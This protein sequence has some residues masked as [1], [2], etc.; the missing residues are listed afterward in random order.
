MMKPLRLLVAAAALYVTTGAGV[1]VAQNVV[2][3]QAP[4]GETIEL[5][6]NA[7]KVATATVDANG[8]ATLPLNLRDNTPGKTE[9]DANIFVD[10]CDKLRRVLVV[11]RGQPVAPLQPGCERREISGLYWVRR[12]NTLVVEVGGVNPTFLL[13]K[14][15]KGLEP[16]KP[17]TPSPK[18]LVI[19]GGAGLADFRDAVAISCG[20]AAPCSGKSAGFAYVAGATFWITRFLAAE[21]S[22]IKPSRASANGSGTNYS[23]DSAL[24]TQ[25]VTVAGRLGVPIGPVRL[26]GQ[27]G[28][29]YHYATLK[30]QETINSASQS[31]KVETRGWGWVFGGGMELWVAPAFALYTDAG[32]AGLKGAPVGGGEARFNDRLRFITFGARVRIGG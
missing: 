26:S 13:F 16:D 23:F 30:T 10:V 12:V 29:N 32:F 31:F 7:T 9:I 2:V 5:F 18:G 24:E 6:L 19:F 1:A 15:E 28:T 14:G 27:V 4:A 21:G 22:Y 17:W 8:D 3:R 20:D 25:V 11:E